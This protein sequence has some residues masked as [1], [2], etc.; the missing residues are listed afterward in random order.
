VSEAPRRRPSQPGRETLAKL[1]GVAIFALTAFQIYQSTKVGVTPRGTP[2]RE[3]LQHLHIS[4]GLI[5]L[6]LTVARLWLWGVLPR[7]DRPVRVP[8]EADALARGCNLAF[9]LTLLALCLTGPL[10]AWSEGHAVSLFG[11]L[12]LPALLAPSYRASVT[13]GYLHSAIGFWILL[14]VGFSVLVAL[15]QAIRYGARPWRMLPA[16]PWAPNDGGVAPAYAEPV[17]VPGRALHAVLFAALLGFAAWMPYQIFG[18]VPFTTSKQLVESGP[19]PAADPYVDVGAM[20][21]LAGQTQQ[22][23]MWCRFCHSFEAGGPHGVGPNLHRVYGRR[24]ASA[25]GFY[26]SEAFVDAGRGGLVWDEA[27][28]SRLIEDPERF[29]DGQHRMRYKPITDPQARA[30]IV[31]ALKVATK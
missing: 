3:A 17:G 31:A 10:F 22:D 25:P 8:I 5:V 12:S 28:V 29:L 1:L 14:L 19:R 27:A 4:I 24:A 23:F 11:V 13:L 16:F 15:W 26:Y 2:A 20:P 21:T 18:V 7:P 6:V 30:Q 9:Y